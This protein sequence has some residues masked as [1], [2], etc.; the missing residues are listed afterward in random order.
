MG[1]LSPTYWV[2][3]RKRFELLGILIA[4]IGTLVSGLIYCKD[5][6][7]KNEQ[8]IGGAWK[9]TFSIQESSK[10]SYIG[11]SAGYKIYIS[12]EGNVV[13]GKGEKFWVNDIEIPSKQHDPL[14]FEGTITDGVLKANY[15]LT[16]TKRKSYGSFIM[17]IDNTEITGT[18]QGSAADA[19]GKVVATKE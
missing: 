4:I 6:F 15:E 8:E 5:N 2:R 3:A 1:K 14:T 12:Q 19:K 9:F 18:F 17:K 7:W 11:L 13:K 16:G 10:P